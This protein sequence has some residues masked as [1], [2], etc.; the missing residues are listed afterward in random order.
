MGCKVTLLDNLTSASTTS[1]R[2][3][4]TITPRYLL[5]PT[6]HKRRGV[7]G[8]LAWGETRVHLFDVGERA[9]VLIDVLKGALG[10]GDLGL[11]EVGEAAGLRRVRDDAKGGGGLQLQLQLLVTSR[12]GEG[13]GRRRRIVEGRRQ[14]VGGVQAPANVLQEEEGASHGDAG[15][16]DGGL[17]GRK[18]PGGGRGQGA[19]GRGRWGERRE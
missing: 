6:A 18:G 16:Q 11:L 12:G 4:V 1:P 14:G 2:H 13:E 10:G 3:H 17:V 5:D 19:S 8:G 7:T 15:V 9:L